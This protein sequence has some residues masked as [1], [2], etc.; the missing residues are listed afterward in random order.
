M[1][2]GSR[3][4]TFVEVNPVITEVLQHNVSTFGI[5][6]KAE[7]LRIKAE[8]FCARKGKDFDVIFADPPYAF[9]GAPA[10]IQAI[11]DNGLLRPDGLLVWEHPA[12]LQLPDTGDFVQIKQRTFGTTA[13]TFLQL[14][15]SLGDSL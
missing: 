15:S 6:D 7:V 14:E 4:V 1:S 9:E 2:R 8:S 12:R 11:A 3:S 10:M 13:V 5:A